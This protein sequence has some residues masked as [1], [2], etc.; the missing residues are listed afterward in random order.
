MRLWPDLLASQGTIIDSG[1][2]PAKGRRT[3]AVGLLCSCS[4]LLK[5]AAATTRP[6]HRPAVEVRRAAELYAQGWTG[7]AAETQT[8]RRVHRA[9]QAAASRALQPCL[10]LGLAVR[11][12]QRRPHAET[13]PRRRR[14]HP[15]HCSTSQ[16]L[17]E[18]LGQRPRQC[19]RPR[20]RR[21]II[22]GRALHDRLVLA[23]SAVDLGRPPC[24]CRR[25]CGDE[26]TSASNR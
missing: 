16:R 22:A 15:A 19:G 1:L 26:R 21:N 14:V 5:H 4:G 9:R 23:G 11:H 25:P 12:H 13:A 24:D 17:K 10:G 18:L 20:V 3:T 6:R 8:A 2:G 7:A